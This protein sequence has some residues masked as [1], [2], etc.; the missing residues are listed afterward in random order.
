[1][2]EKK[3]LSTSKPAEADASEE[4]ELLLDLSQELSPRQ[5]VQELDR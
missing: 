5:I 1:M 4:D 2:S 3:I